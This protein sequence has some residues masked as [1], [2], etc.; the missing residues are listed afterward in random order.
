MGYKLYRGCYSSSGRQ[1]PTRAQLNG[2]SCSEFKTVLK[3]LGFKIPRDFFRRASIAK[4]GSRLY[5]FRWW[6]D[7]FVCDISCDM[8]DF[9]RW[10]NSVDKTVPISYIMAGYRY[11]K[12]E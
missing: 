5:R 4:R 12:G 3:R 8:I 1:K 10:A 2:L 9:D 6:S 7:D 11:S